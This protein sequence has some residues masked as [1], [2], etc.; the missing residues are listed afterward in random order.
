MVSMKVNIRKC[1]ADC[2]ICLDSWT[3]WLGL[4]LD[5]TS[6][7]THWC[8]FCVKNFGLMMWNQTI[9]LF[10]GCHQSDGGKWIFI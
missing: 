2:P 1:L 4:F 7:V 3:D 10:S 5:Q 8:L 6:H 9:I